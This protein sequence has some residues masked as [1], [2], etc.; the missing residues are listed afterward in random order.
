MTDAE[1]LEALK[2]P[3][4][5]S[6]RD[7]QW[8]P[9]IRQGGPFQPIELE[10]AR[11]VVGCVPIR[12]IKDPTPFLQ[13]R[14]LIHIKA[15]MTDFG[16]PRWAMIGLT[17]AAIEAM[18]ELGMVVPAEPTAPCD[19]EPRDGKTARKRKAIVGQLILDGIDAPPETA[20]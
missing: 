18:N 4:P 14:G 6:E 7:G 2:K 19:E 20:P 16:M 5:P 9:A 13:V 17:Q 8:E 3:P 15:V 11:L 12:S 10:G 1:I